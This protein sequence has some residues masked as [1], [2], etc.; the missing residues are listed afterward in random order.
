MWPQDP[1]WLKKD[2]FIKRVTDM[3]PSLS[4]SQED[5]QRQFLPLPPD[6]S[7]NAVSPAGDTQACHMALYL[8]QI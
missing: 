7:S 5:G 2:L 8:P 4:L 1:R 6:P 3:L